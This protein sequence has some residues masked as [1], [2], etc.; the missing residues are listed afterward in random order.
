MN[1]FDQGRRRSS[2]TI[3]TPDSVCSTTSDQDPTLP[4]ATVADAFRNVETKRRRASV[5]IWSDPNLVALANRHIK[6]PKEE[7]K[8]KQNVKTTE[9]VPMS[10][11]QFTADGQLSSLSEAILCRIMNY[12]DFPSIIQFAFTSKRSRELVQQSENILH[13]L[14]LSSVNKRVTDSSITNILPYTGARVKHLKLSN[15]FY[16]TDEGFATLVN[17]LP[18]VQSMDL[19]SCWLLTDKSMA[20]LAASCPQ[21]TKLNLSNCRKISDVGIFRL[22]DGKTSELQELSLSYCKR[23]TD[24]TMGYLVDYCADSLQSL[25]LQRC[26]RITD[27]GF[28]AWSRAEFS[29]LRYLNLT[30]CSFLTDVA[31]A[32]LVAAAKHLQHLCISFCCA[33]SDNAME[34]LA[35]LLELEV[36]DAS[37][38]GA[39]VSDVS[40]RSLLS[41]NDRRIKSLSLRGC[42]RVT[43]ACVEAILERACLSTLNISQC[44]GVS[45]GVKETIRSS[46]NVQELVA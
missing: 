17:A 39:A 12:L 10:P 32:H 35:S 18:N 15:C 43:D 41:R 29:R 21:V 33:L 25:N 13:T 28:E 42:V 16:L 37:F 38:C 30:D 1:T 23:L 3:I 6:E 36:L 14:D 22:L 31:V 26:T 5:A 4:A 40:I 24:T 11:A 7:S 34:E 44:P 8:L 46:G 20:T 2:A 19:N 9:D 27:K 45:M